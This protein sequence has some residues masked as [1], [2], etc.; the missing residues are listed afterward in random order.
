MTTTGPPWRADAIEVVTLADVTLLAEGLDF[1]EGPVA[2]A[3]GGVIVTE[4]D[5]AR[6]TRIGPDGAVEVV[7]TC[8]GGPNGAA[9]GPDG[10][11]YVCNNGGRYASGNYQGG[12]VDRVEIGTG[13]IERL[14]T[15]YQGRRLSGPNDL[16]F[17]NAGGFW[18]SDLGKTRGRERDV[19]SIY[20]AGIDGNSLVEAIH[21]AEMPN[22][23]GLSP[24]GATVYYAETGTARL[25]ARRV[26]GPGT[27]APLEGHG[28]ESVL[29]GLPGHQG[30]DSLAV[31]SL[32]N[33]CVAMLVTGG[34]TV[35]APDG[36]SVVRYVLGSEFHDDMT[37]NICFGG[38]DLTTAYITL[39]HTG[40]VV[41][42]RWPVPGLRLAYNA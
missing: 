23:I 19:G 38:P 40:R 26:T 7:A 16:V 28:S 37:T 5:S 18:F 20:Y 13:A 32:G 34:V 17:D 22:G 21:P 36:G 14:Y 2:T 33:V 4:I 30:F 35:I 29:A 25:R 41:T 12:W 15:E 8:D 24:D 3:D 9:I 42:A 31:D 1:P 10:A 6:I 39:G 11:L 27:V